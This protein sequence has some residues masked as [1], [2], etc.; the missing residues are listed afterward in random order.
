MKVLTS[1]LLLHAALLAGAHA[2]S[3]VFIVSRVTDP[4]VDAEE[5]SAFRDALAAELAG[6]GFSTS[7]RGDRIAE[8]PGDGKLTDAAT[9][10]QARQAGADFALAATLSNRNEE[11]RQ[12][13]GYG[14]ETS[15][16]I[17][18]LSFSYRL[19]RVTDG[20]SIQG[21]TGAV[22]KTFRST[23]GAVTASADA[24][25]DLIGMAAGRIAAE[26]A[27]AI[28]PGDLA[29]DAGESAAVEFTVI[30]RGM[31]MTVPEVTELESGDLYVTGERGDVTLDAVTVLL[32]G[33]VVGSALEPI[34]AS[35]GLHELTLQR[36]GFEDWRR[37]VNISPSLELVVRLKA[38]DEE[39]ERFREQAGFL[40]SLR[41]ERTLTDAEAEKIRGIAAMFARS[42]YR[43]DIR[44]DSKQDIRV[45]TDEAITIEQNNRTLMG[46]NPDN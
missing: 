12:F 16:R 35:R 4:A 18:S 6:Y 8:E 24:T 5:A 10:G 22:R 36:E 14:V 2:S 25:S 20:E 41:A 9:L 27:A 34:T 23:E 26:T 32:D 28:A 13:S 21:G 42:G 30:P 3:T 33:I 31:G 40:E 46:D 29:A 17:H 37:T 45:D 11:V 39:I 7:V 43:F 1:L 19:L 15:N 38:T 44:S